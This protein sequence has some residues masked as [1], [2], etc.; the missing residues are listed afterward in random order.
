MI[1]FRESLL[2]TVEGEATCW[3][4]GSKDV[5]QARQTQRPNSPT[6]ATHSLSAAIKRGVQGR[7]PGFDWV[8]R[9]SPLSPSL[10]I[11]DW[12]SKVA[13]LEALVER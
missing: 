6:S 5:D 7:R 1:H 4:E 10:I 3:A 8:G 13:S 9:R 11:G 2:M 12:P